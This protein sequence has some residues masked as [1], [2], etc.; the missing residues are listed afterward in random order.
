MSSP[1]APAQLV[2]DS[3]FAE[4][5]RIVRP[6]SSGGMGS[7]YV[8]QQ[9]STEKLRALKIMN[10]GIVANPEFRKRFAL[11]A[12]VGSRIRSEHVV[13]VI[14]AGV[15][16]A[17]QT[18][19]IVMELLEGEDLEAALTK[20]ERFPVEEAREVIGQLCHA[21]GE[22]HAQGIV[23][24]D[25]KPENV[26][27]ALARRRGGSYT[28]KVLDFGIARVVAEARA[29]A[30][31]AALGTPLWMAPEQH[32]GAAVTPA[33]DVWAI[34]LLA[35]RMLAG[36]VFWRARYD[37]QP[38]LATLVTEMRVA[39]IP[40]AS[41][42][43]AEYGV[44]ERLPAGFDGWFARTVTR[45]VAAR[46]P[47]AAAAYAALEPLLG[48]A[49]P[50]VASPASSAPAAVV[51]PPPALGPTAL[52]PTAL[53]P[54]AAHHAPVARVAATLHDM[55]P[56]GAS[57]APVAPAAPAPPRARRRSPALLFV[58][59]AVVLLG[60]VAGA[61]YLL[62]NRRHGASAGLPVDCEEYLRVLECS[63]RSADAATRYTTGGG[64]RD[65]MRAMPAAQCQ[66]L[67]ARISAR[68]PGCGR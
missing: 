68:T 10:P 31:M 6:L 36:R 22:A 18:P 39:P 48:V 19:F 47:D 16:A 43:A 9:I 44:G 65:S 56:P 1:A 45:D 62:G 27:L 26:F 54:T 49:A 41:T 46:F 4:D 55:R 67:A 63:Y 13:E 28:V 42:R 14:A 29:T 21:V 59:L 60:G 20:R 25:L 57:P 7:V 24:R 66:K 2:V 17:T 38:S 40:P 3:V 64:A 33:A 58:A 51:A 32:G 52:A 53:A 11:E 34:G 50:S 23:H 15:D 61:W 35:F 12:R 30:V 5:Y 37:P 8:A